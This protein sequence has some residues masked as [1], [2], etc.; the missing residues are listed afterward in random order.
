MPGKAMIILILGMI[1]ITGLM[2]TGILRS[3]NNIS[4]NMVT[5][6]QKKMTYY[7][8]QSGANI[9]LDKLRNNPTSFSYDSTT[10]SPMKG[11]Q[12][13][14]QSYIIGKVNIRVMGT[15]SSIDTVISKA[16]TTNGSDTITYTSIASKYPIVIPTMTKGAFTSATG[17]T[18]SFKGSPHDGI[19]GHDYTSAGVPI[20]PPTGTYAIWTT[21]FVGI[22]GSAATVGGYV[23]GKDYPLSNKL[24]TNIVRQIQIYP[25]NFPTNPD[26][27]MG[28]PQ[29][30][31]LSIAQSQVGGSHYY[32]NPPSSSATLSGVTYVDWNSGKYNNNISG[33]GILI[34]NNLTSQPQAVAIKQSTFTGIV[35]LSNNISLS[36][37]Q[38][39]VIGAVVVTGPVASSTLE[40]QGQGHINYSSQ[41]ILNVIKFTTAQT[42]VW[43]ER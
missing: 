43:Y 31:M 15:P 13:G 40:I 33:T 1:I 36:V 17:V 32:S 11:A 21:G 22:N 25:G 2:L 24:D 39:G 41:A 14:A 4:K 35:I 8:A 34:I 23:N 30:T 12:T 10:F 5:D 37:K 42:I 29:G 19:D 6:Y 7:I 38:G 28:Y 27:V 9:G 18:Y 16:F 3:S 20:S 26:Q